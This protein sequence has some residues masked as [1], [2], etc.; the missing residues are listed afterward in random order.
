MLRLPFLWLL[1]AVAA[2]V[3]FSLQPAAATHDEEL[4]DKPN[5]NYDALYKA[6]IALG[7]A[8]F[9][10]WTPVHYAEE[11]ERLAADKE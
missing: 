7:D 4:E 9:G 5:V 1:V 6:Y 11:L 8:L 3:C 2:L 10:N